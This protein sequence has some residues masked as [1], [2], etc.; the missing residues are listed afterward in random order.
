MELRQEKTKISFFENLIVT[1]DRGDL[2]AN[3]A[4]DSGIIQ[5]FCGHLR[6][7]WEKLQSFGRLPQ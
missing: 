3:F 5:G 4:S 1:L 6:S 2:D 7:Y